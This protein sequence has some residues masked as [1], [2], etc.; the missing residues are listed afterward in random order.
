MR[1][2]MQSNLAMAAVSSALRNLALEVI[3]ISNDLR[4]LAS[5]PNT[6][7]AE[8]NLP[9]L[10]PGSSI[11]PGKINP[12][13]P[14]LAAMVSFQVIGNDVAVAMAGQA[15]QLELNVMM[16]TMSYSVLQSIT[17]LT[18]MLR[19]FTTKCIDGITVDKGRCECYGQ[20]T[21]SLATALD[22]YMRYAEAG[23]SAEDGV[24]SGR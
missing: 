13:I 18:N 1:Y 9:A 12:V 20:A 21:V 4:L 8:I 17:I 11:M 7:F 14:E 3:R 6:G 22:Y 23:E 16:P 2:A 5:G 19:Q 15:G 24:T 10:Q